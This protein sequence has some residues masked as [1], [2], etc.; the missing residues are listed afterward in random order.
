MDQYSD[1]YVSRD[2]QLMV[3]DSQTTVGLGEDGVVI[4]RNVATGER[5]HFCMSDFYDEAQFRP[6]SRKE[7]CGAFGLP[8]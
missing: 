6:V 8:E 4:A 7:L 1:L 3:V 2:N 5:R